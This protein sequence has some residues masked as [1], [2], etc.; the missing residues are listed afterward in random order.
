MKQRISGLKI[1]LAFLLLAGQQGAFAPAVSAKDKSAAAD[2]N[3]LTFR[4]YQL[5]DGNYGGKLGNFYLIT[6]VYRDPSSPQEEL[7]HILRVDYDK[8]RGFGKLN[9]YVRSVGKIQ[10]DQMKAYTTKEF[11]EFG[12]SD[13][14]KFVKTDPGPLGKTGDVYLRAEGDRPLATTPITDDARKSYETI[15]T[16]YLIPALQKK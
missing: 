12:E 3:D 7:Q 11:Y 2:P 13:Q 9:I 14:E 4:L 6:D 8:D 16:Q 15:L 1:L 5:L 10:P